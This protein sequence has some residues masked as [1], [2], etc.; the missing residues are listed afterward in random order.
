MDHPPQLR[1]F[2]GWDQ[3]SG[4]A[5]PQRRL[6]EL[7]P[8]SAGW[9]L[10]GNRGKGCGEVPS[11]LPRRTCNSGRFS[12]KPCFNMR[13]NLE[14]SEKCSFCWTQGLGPWLLRENRLYVC[15]MKNLGKVMMS[16]WCVCAC[17]RQGKHMQTYAN[18]CT[19]T[20]YGQIKRTRANPLAVFFSLM[21]SALLWSPWGS[22]QSLVSLQGMGRP[23]K[24]MFWGDLPGEAV[25]SLA[26]HFNPD[27]HG[28]ETLPSAPRLQTSSAFLTLG[29]LPTKL[30]L[31]G[32]P[33]LLSC[34]SVQFSSVTQS[35]L[36]L[37]DSTDCNAPSLPVHHQLPEFTQIHVH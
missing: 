27:L 19:F 36:T 31:V 15:C 4:A 21:I 32:H 28:E 17:M 6:P 13:V 25:S 20:H 9:R 7:S 23:R 37:C 8:G 2:P 26:A 24:V 5:K 14:P 10:R 35:C 3:G 29:H 12:S 18:V 33:G 11:P 34:G 1:A 30:H 22:V 16:Q